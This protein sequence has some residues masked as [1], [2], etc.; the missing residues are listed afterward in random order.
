LFGQDITPYLPEYIKPFAEQLRQLPSGYEK[1]AYAASLPADI[2]QGDVFDQV[3]FASLDDNGET[4][5]FEPFGMVV[6]NTCDVQPGQGETLLVAPIVDLEDYR[7]NSELDKEALENHIRAL[8]ENKISQL[9]FL[10]EG[11]GLRRSFVDFGKI[12]SIS[13]SY[14]H[15]DHVQ[16]RLISLSQP[17]HYLLLVKLAHHFCRP[18]A[19]DANRK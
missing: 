5:R 2:Y 6:S 18:E 12:C 9:M 7:Q 19:R 10:P 13:L 8:I 17:G 15:A 1:W 16:K 14:F 3:E 11:P 4:I